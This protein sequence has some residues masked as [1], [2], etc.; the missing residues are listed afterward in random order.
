MAVF[1]PYI[2]FGLIQISKNTLDSFRKVNRNRTCLRTTLNS[3]DS[4]KFESVQSHMRYNFRLGTELK[5]SFNWHWY[6]HIPAIQQ[7]RQFFALFYQTP[8][9]LEYPV[10]MSF[11]HITYRITMNANEENIFRHRNSNSRPRAFKPSRSRQL[12]N[13]LPFI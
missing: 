7:K 6:H 8:R 1:G 11:K 13:S 3:F 10:R 5:K 4:L 12:I 2:A 9:K